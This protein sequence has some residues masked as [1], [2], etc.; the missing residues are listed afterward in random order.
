MTRYVISYDVTDDRR[1]ARL[2]RALDDYGD[3]VQRSVFEADL[4]EA[5][6]A[7]VLRRVEREID[8]KEDSVRVYPLCAACAGK[9]IKRGRNVEL[10]D[11]D[12]VV[13]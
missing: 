3:R 11:R 2:A 7:E 8:G 1:R 4:E 5:H 10:D 12:A 13:V 9:T 6:L